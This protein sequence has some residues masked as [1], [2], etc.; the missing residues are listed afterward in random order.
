MAMSRGR[1]LLTIALSIT[2]LFM[3]TI[4]YYF[5][6]QEET[7]KK[8]LPGL[9]LA[10]SNARYLDSISYFFPRFNRMIDLWDT[11]RTNRLSGKYFV[12]YSGV[13]EK[14]FISRDI[15]S[16]TDARG[17]PRD[18]TKNPGG[19]FMHPT[20][21]KNYVA[22]LHDARCMVIVRG[23][24]YEER[25]YYPVN[26]LGQ[27]IIDTKRSFSVSSHKFRAYAIDLEK[28]EITAF[29]EFI[30]E[31]L[32]RS[33]GRYFLTYDTEAKAMLGWLDSMS[34]VALTKQQ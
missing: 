9:L 11:P 10:Q 25:T 1:V 5:I 19:M 23:T 30:P 13:D 3:S 8:E 7:R 34:T 28:K 2:M 17:N 21:A 15:N 27:E 31:E 18:Y 4:V 26:S 14:L 12:W 33:V 24:F 22:D 16:L 20:S 6:Q 29:Q 32:P